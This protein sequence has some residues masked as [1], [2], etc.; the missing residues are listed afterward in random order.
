MLFIRY[1]VV[2]EGFTRH[3]VTIDF[4]TICSI[5]CCVLTF[6]AIGFT[7]SVFSIPLDKFPIQGRY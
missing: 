3:P 7:C 4:I 6:S 2:L 5:V 1:P